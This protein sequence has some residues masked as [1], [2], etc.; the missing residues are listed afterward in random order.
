[1]LQY[2]DN[3]I[4]RH[5]KTLSQTM[6]FHTHDLVDESMYELI[7][8]AGFLGAALWIPEI[9]DMN[10]YHVSLSHSTAQAGVAYL[11]PQDDLSILIDNVLDAFDEVDPAKILTKEKLHTMTHTPGD[12][13]RFGPAVRKATEVFEKFNGVF[14]RTIRLGNGQANSRDAARQFLRI[15]TTSH[16]AT[17]GFFHDSYEWRQAGHAVRQLLVDSPI[18]QHH[19]GWVPPAKVE[20]GM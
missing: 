12:V 17:G 2:K 20:P 6:A 7:K 1:M 8:A 10:E 18:L 19:F 15:D 16:L 3:L 9:D 5:M 14:R 4:G 11:L 13:R